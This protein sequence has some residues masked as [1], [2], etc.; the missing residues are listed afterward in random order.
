MTKNDFIK[1]YIDFIKKESDLTT[2][3]KSHNKIVDEH[4]KFLENNKECTFFKE[5]IEEFMTNKDIYIKFYAATAAIKYNI[6]PKKAFKIR[7]RISR[8]FKY[9]NS[10]VSL[11]AQMFLDM[12]KNPQDYK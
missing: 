3:Y 12:Y 2:D 1:K 6:N 9:R 4:I 8:S 5:V 10:S 7:K 11:L